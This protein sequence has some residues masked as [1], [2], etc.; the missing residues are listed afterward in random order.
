[1]ALPQVFRMAVEVRAIP[2]PKGIPMGGYGWGS[3]RRS[4]G[5]MANPLKV[6]C[7]ILVPP[8]GQR[9]VLVQADVISIP[10]PV[11]EE[12]LSALLD[13][14]VVPNAAGFVL[15][16]S[17]T[18]SGPM[19]GD[20]PDPYVLLGSEDA[21]QD[22]RAFTAQF[23]N[24]VVD[25][26][27][28][29]HQQPT[30]PVTLGYAE[31][32]AEVGA[33]R[34]GLPYAPREVPVLV[35]RRADNYDL[36]AVLAGHT[37][38]PVCAPREGSPDADYCGFAVDEVEKRLGVPAIFFQGAAG[39][40][41]PARMDVAFSALRLTNAIVAT[42]RNAAFFP[43][44]GPVSARIE[45]VQLKYAV[46][47]DN[48]AERKE[49]ENKYRK[50]VDDAGEGGESGT[51]VEAAGVRH[52]LRMLDE[53]KGAVTN[54]MP[55]TIQKI[56]LGG[57]TIFTMSHEVL[58]GW[59]VGTKAQW[60]TAKPFEPLWIMGYAN[61]IDC[62]VPAYDILSEGDDPEQPHGEA[63]WTRGG[64]P[65][66][67]G[68]GTYG[69]SYSLIAPLKA[70]SGPTDPEGVEGTLVPRIRTLLLGQ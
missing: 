50:R 61:H 27:I 68:P 20:K 65:T 13:A 44:S 22:A 66:V 57:L 69:N 55:M 21:A 5:S 70:G 47:L 59:H 46:D 10:R 8:S 52:A 54:H 42:V 15:A 49:L 29:A 51:S 53:L 32:Y 2:M 35:A 38:H 19:I 24:L 36:F 43:L 23:V 9:V 14:Q 25:T 41:N 3:E 33:N 28:A 6:R 4:N 18:H 12:I 62:Y 37:C 56:D 63:G 67:V 16:Q 48:P 7:V 11:Y 34:R 39:D 58:S 45:T 31:G 60:A 1:M 17:H 26:A 30:T 40:I 64:D